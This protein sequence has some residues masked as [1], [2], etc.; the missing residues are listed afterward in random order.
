M[1]FQLITSTSALLIYSSL[2]TTFADAYADADASASKFYLKGAAQA[3]TLKSE[4]HLNA[5]L[6]QSNMEG[7]NGEDLSYTYQLR[8]DLS[9]PLSYDYNV[10]GEGMAQIDEC[11]G[12]DSNVIPTNF[13]W[14]GI[15]LQLPD[16]ARLSDWTVFHRP[17]M[18]PLKE[19]GFVQLFGDEANGV[20]DLKFTT[21]AD[22]PIIRARINDIM[23]VFLT[24]D[25]PTFEFDFSDGRSVAKAGWETG[26]KCKV[27]E[28]ANGATLWRDVV[29]PTMDVSLER[30]V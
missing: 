16:D 10:H 7:D 4:E 19:D 27:A 20:V 26:V 28:S 13:T 11:I 5:D 17:I 3:A 23:P 22:R 18:Q 25:W 30:L 6:G 14:Y 12:W 15:S 8:M 2:A 29:T 21:S 1:K 9:S 24:L